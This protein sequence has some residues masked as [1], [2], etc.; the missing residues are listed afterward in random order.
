M[1]DTLT[2]E[3]S[4]EEFSRLRYPGRGC[5][6]GM[7]PEGTNIVLGYF[8]T[9]RSPASKNR[10]LEKQGNAISTAVL[11]PS[12]PSGD[13]AITLYTAITGT[14]NLYIVSNGNHTATI[15]DL[16]TGQIPFGGFNQG[17]EQITYENDEFSTPR[18]AGAFSLRTGEPRIELA[19][20]QKDPTNNNPLR[21]TWHPPLKQG[22]GYCITTY[23]GTSE[24]EIVPF[25]QEDP[26][27]LPIQGSARTIAKELWGILPPKHRVA[28]AILLVDRDGPSGLAITNEREKIA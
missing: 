13:P 25:S 2:P 1:T 11:D 3:A 26:W 18:I 28:I 4:L 7:N 24:E 23:K 16:D 22:I 6:I 19:L 27:I 17:I 15:L 12:L 9:G 20:V 14:D 10:V 21:K 5:I 8:I